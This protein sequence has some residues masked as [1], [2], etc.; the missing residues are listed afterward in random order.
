MAAISPHKVVGDQDAPH[1]LGHRRRA[2]AANGF[3][4][5][6]HIGFDLAKAEFDIVRDTARAAWA[7][8]AV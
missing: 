4:S 7:T 8:V 5:F 3:E 1:F 2:F 6:E